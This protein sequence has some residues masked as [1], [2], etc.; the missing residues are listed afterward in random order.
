VR[1]GQIDSGYR[2]EWFVMLQNT[3]NKTIVI[4]PL[5][6]DKVV[7][8]DRIEY[9]LTKAIC[10]AALEVSPYVNTKE[11]SYEELSKI[12]SQRGIGKLGSS[13]K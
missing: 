12:P 11:I 6:K 2:G 5:V 7:Y 8:D 4:T 13:G 9:P 1:C 10:Q 3:T